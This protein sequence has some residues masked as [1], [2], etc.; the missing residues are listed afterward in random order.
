M[1]GRYVTGRAAE[2]YADEFEV[3]LTGGAGPGLPPDQ[4]GPNY[5]VSPT[6]L[7]PVVLERLPKTA[8]APERTGTMRWL[9]LFRWG[10]VPSWAKDSSRAARMINARAESLSDRPSFAT[11]ARKRRCL[12]PADGWYEWQ[13]ASGG[14]AGQ[15]RS[16]KQPFYL[17]SRTG[18]VLALAGVY[19]FWHVPGR[20]PTDPGSWWASF[21]IVTTTAEPGLRHIHDRMP[22][23][24]PRDRWEA[25]LDPR[26]QDLETV[27]SLLIPALSGEV[28]TIP[29]STAVN[30][31]RNNGPELIEPVPER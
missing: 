22:L 4:A 28:V 5:N 9:R 29:V 3:D 14:S 15:G 23:V 19:E 17:T 27:R 31:V 12:V 26:L 21:A 13:T 25:W 10:L 30:V 2:E 8:A 20:P 11:A 1:C 16:G 6:S 7:A 18:T 24:L